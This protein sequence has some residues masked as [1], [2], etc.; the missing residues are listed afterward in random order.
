MWENESILKEPIFKSQENSDMKRTSALFLLLPFFPVAFFPGQPRTGSRPD[1]VTAY[2]AGKP[3]GPG[4]CQECH[5]DVADKKVLHAPV[6]E[7]CDNC[8]RVDMN[9]HPEKVS[10]GLFLVE[11]MPKLCF[12]CHEPVK[13]EIDSSRIVHA[14]V[15]DKRMC[16]NCHSPHSTADKKLLKGGK[17]ETCL[18]CHSAEIQAGDR[19]IRNIGQI[20][21]T[22][23]VIHP[24][25]NGGC[26]SCH[27]G[28]ASNENYLLIGSFPSALYAPGKK[29]NYAVCWECHDSDLLEAQKTESATGFRNGD[30]NLHYLH[31]FGGRGRSCVICHDVHAS[32]NKFLVQDKVS[33]GKWAFTLNFTPDETGG[34]CSPGCH[35]T[36]TYKR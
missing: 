4:K 35:G 7:G 15:R 18:T 30:K 10:T 2:S 33:F 32:N 3:A 5:T 31:L 27:K 13:K 24:A 14:P 16:M 1:V 23:K 34:S 17:T 8:H 12:E 6:G 36:L 19:T 26:G 25:L 9:Q 28:H 20:V 21:K 29:E 22:G 11:E